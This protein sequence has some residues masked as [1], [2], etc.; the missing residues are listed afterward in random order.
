MSYKNK[1]PASERGPGFVVRCLIFLET[2]SRQEISESNHD[3]EV[4]TLSTGIVLF[5]DRDLKLLVKGFIREVVPAQPIEEEPFVVS[6][7]IP[8]K[9]EGGQISFIKTHRGTFP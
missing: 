3:A 2:V 9:R 4:V 5:A 8:E 7:Y 6:A 1:D